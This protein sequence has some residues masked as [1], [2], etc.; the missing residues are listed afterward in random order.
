[1]VDKSAF[2]V[3]KPI[4]QGE[5]QRKFAQILSKAVYNNEAVRSFIHRESL[6]KFDNAYH[7]LYGKVKNME[8]E[9][10]VTFK[11]ALDV[12]A[13]D[14][15]TLDQI[16]KSAPLIN[17]HIPDMAYLG[18][19]SAEEWDI[20][21][22]H[23]GVVPDLGNESN[24]VFGNGDSVYALLSTE[25]PT[26]PLLVVKNNTRVVLRSPATKS[27]EAVYDFVDDCYNPA[28]NTTSTKSKYYHEKYRADT[29]GYDMGF[30]PYLYLSTDVIDQ[31]LIDA[32]NEKHPVLY[33]REY[34]YYDS[35]HFHK[36]VK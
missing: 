26:N 18:G 23:V 28:Y 7:V 35:G 27:S 31:R 13:E 8:V 19:F 1:M 5:A 21:D 25:V 29:V 6:K 20:S 2:E 9:A 36:N 24:T 34:L 32:Y 11:Q 22:N 4:S 12:Y 16:E 15:N 10:G 3:I 30:E 17:I 33:P 14:V